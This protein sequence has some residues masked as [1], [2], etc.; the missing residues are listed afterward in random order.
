MEIGHIVVNIGVATGKNGLEVKLANAKGATGLAKG[1]FFA[2]EQQ[3]HQLL[4]GLSFGES[5]SLDEFVGDE[6]A[7]GDDSPMP[8]D[9]YSDPPLDELSQSLGVKVFIN[10]E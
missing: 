8:T 2:L 10:T 3:Q 4:Q 6:K 1:E 9:Q 5:G 7:H